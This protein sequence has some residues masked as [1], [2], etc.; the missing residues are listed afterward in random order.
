MRF[1]ES[2]TGSYGLVETE[3]AGETKL[4]GCVTDIKM[5]GVIDV[6]TEPNPVVSLEICNE[7]L[8][9]DKTECGDCVCLPFLRSALTAKPIFP[10]DYVVITIRK[11]TTEEVNSYLAERDR[12]DGEQVKAIKKYQ[13]TKE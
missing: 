10:G 9:I 5:S 11:A 4:I 7:F 8:F 2:E 6:D 13:G 12:I 1:D 3:N